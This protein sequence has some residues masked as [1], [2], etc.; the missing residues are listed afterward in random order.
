MITTLILLTLYCTTVDVLNSAQLSQV[1]QIF[2][3]RSN[4]YRFIK[5]FDNSDEISCFNGIKAISMLI[6][7]SAHSVQIRTWFPF[8]RGDDIDKWKDNFLFYQPSAWM[9][10]NFL[11]LSGFLA[12]KS[13]IRKMNRYKY[14][15]ICKTNFWEMFNSN[16]FNF[17]EAIFIRYM[18][19][20]PAYVVVILSYTSILQFQSHRVPYLFVS[21]FCEKFWWSGLLHAQNI[22]N[23]LEMVKLKEKSVFFS[24]LS[25]YFQCMNTSW[26]L[27]VEF[28]LFLFV[29][30]FTWIAKKANK[31]VGIFLTI[32]FTFCNCFYCF[33]F[34]V[35]YPASIDT[36]PL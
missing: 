11:I 13:N 22:F 14:S 32:V 2:S 24:H 9:V 36:R 27:S 33:M 23:T 15:A 4:F 18:R 29:P 12:V 7:I 25:S 31:A 21:G 1:T 3:I 19:L 20:T 30:L 5:N 34:F 28:Q 6:I 10:E 35:R 8:R 26:Y 16:Q 17:F